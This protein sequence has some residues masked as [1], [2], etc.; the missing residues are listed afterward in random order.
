MGLPVHQ[1]EGTIH[2]STLFDA[3]AFCCT[4]C[5]E[6][7][8]DNLLHFFSSIGQIQS[9]FDL[10]VVECQQILDVWTIFLFYIAD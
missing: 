10:F 3:G 5:F 7:L 1:V 8:L 2:Y 6:G 9:N 4:V